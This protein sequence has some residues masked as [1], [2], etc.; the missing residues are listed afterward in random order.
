ML[1]SWDIMS[2]LMLE[3]G[4]IREG[5]KD[6]EIVGFNCAFDEENSALDV[7]NVEFVLKML[8]W[9]LQSDVESEG[10]STKTGG[11]R[12]DGHVIPAI[13]PFYVCKTQDRKSK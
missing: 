7:M 13:S 12:E 10:R 2:P 6:P 1:I 9:K 4:C 11:S 8:T 5:L 3:C